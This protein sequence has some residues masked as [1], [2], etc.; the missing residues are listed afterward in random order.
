[1][2]GTVNAGHRDI[3]ADY[4]PIMKALMD[5]VSANGVP[6]QQDLNYGVPHGV[7]M[8]PNSLNAEQIR[9]DAAREWLLPNYARSNLHVLVCLIKP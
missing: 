2:N 7:S 8:F 5:T 4:S 6:V 9:S 3:G 1:M